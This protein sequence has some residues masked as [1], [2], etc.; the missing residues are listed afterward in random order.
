PKDVV[1]I[2]RVALIDEAHATPSKAATGTSLEP[3]ARVER[4]KAMLA[5][6]EMV[7]SAQM[8]RNMASD[9]IHG[10]YRGDFDAVLSRVKAAAAK[11]QAA[12]DRAAASKRR[13]AELR[14]MIEARGL[15]KEP[16]I[17]KVIEKLGPTPS[18]EAVLDVIS[19]IR[20]KLVT[21]ILATEAQAPYPGSRV[22]KDVEI[23]VEQPEITVDQFYTNHPGHKGIPKE[24]P[25]ADGRTR[26]HVLSTDID[27]LVVQPQANNGKARI[28][29]REELKTGMRDKPAK[30]RRQL[31]KGL[32]RLEEA[33]AAQENVR[34]LENG[35]DITDTIDLTT[36]HG[37]SGVTRGP[38][39]RG[40]DDHLGISARDLEVL[41]ENL[42]EVELRL[43]F[44]EGK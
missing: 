29:H 28:V 3:K 34:L 10:R 44:P 15:M 8:H 16:A 30:A 9:D 20:S 26:V 42:I 38:S 25:T 18:R 36:A 11:G 13:A 27:I 35:M 17:R 19:D 40:F 23:W 4:V 2:D 6:D 41:T 24:L 31:D 21:D 39:G 22:H 32:R 43:H 33:A 37:S 5:P 12:N 14:A 1:A 7:K